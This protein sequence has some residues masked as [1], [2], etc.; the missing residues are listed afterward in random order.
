ML[1]RLA[2]VLLVAALCACGSGSGQ[3]GADPKAD[4][5]AVEEVVK[6]FYDGL[7]GRDWDLLFSCLEPDWSLYTPAAE[8]LNRRQFVAGLQVHSPRHEVKIDDIEI[9]FSPD[10]SMAWATY[11]QKASYPW[12]GVDADHNALITSILVRNNEGRWLMSHTHRSSDRA[13]VYLRT[14]PSEYPEARPE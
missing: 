1:P 10:R 7:V 9:R 5:K 14:K 11:R 3:P 8:V 4:R 13:D 2:L 6:R 12:K